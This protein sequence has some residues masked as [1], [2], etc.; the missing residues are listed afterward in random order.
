MNFMYFRPGMDL[1]NHYNTPLSPREKARF[2]REMGDRVRDM[3]NYDLQGFWLNQGKFDEETGHASDMF[4]KPNH[5]TFSTQSKYSN[6]EHEG[7]TWDQVEGK[8]RFT[9]SPWVRSVWTKEAL[10]DYFSKVEPDAI[11]NYGE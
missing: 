5:P 7:G 1:T 2:R 4:K 3:Y 10:S 6:A 9:P 11:L 8:W